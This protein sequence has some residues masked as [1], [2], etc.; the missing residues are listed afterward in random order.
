MKKECIHA[1]HTPTPS[2]AGAGE[3]GPNSDEVTDTVILTRISNIFFGL[4]AVQD[5]IDF[6]KI[7]TTQSIREREETGPM[8]Q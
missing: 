8:K 1:W 2:P 7:L 3:G 5:T 6:G 4:T